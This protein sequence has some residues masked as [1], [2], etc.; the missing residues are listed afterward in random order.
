MLK[1]PLVVPYVSDLIDSLPNG[2]AAHTA[3]SVAFGGS[4]AGTSLTLHTVSDGE[5]TAKRKG[6]AA[7]GTKV[8][9][10]VSHSTSKEN[11]P[12]VTD[13]TLIRYDFTR[14]DAVTGKPVTMSCYS[15]TAL[16]QGATFTSDDARNASATLALFMLLG[17]VRDESDPPRVNDVI[18][19][20]TF[21]R[22]I[23]GE[24]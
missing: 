22:L 21:V 20:N 18:S 2:A 6:T 19:G 17:G 8:S 23:D 10:T 3:L 11:A 13:R 5:G 12:Y 16:P 15:L 4:G 14:I 9:Q 1:D 24:A 7:D